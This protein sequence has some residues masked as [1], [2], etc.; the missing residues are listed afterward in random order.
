MLIGSAVA[1]VAGVLFAVNLGFVNTNDYTVALTLYVWVMIVLGGLGN[2]RGALVGAFIVT[3]L[4]RA[5]VVAAIFLN[6]TGINLEFNYVQYII[7][8][9]VLLAVLRF[10]R[11]GLLPERAETTIAHD[12]LR[13]Q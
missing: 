10:R 5:T 4:T 13:Q 2:Q 6:R 11:Q 3:L 7:F 8:A 9:L 12:D 1:A